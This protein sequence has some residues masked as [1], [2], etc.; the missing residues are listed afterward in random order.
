MEDLQKALQEQGGKTED[1]ILLKRKLE[2]HL[3]KL[4]EA[5]LE[6]QRKREYIEELEP[7]TDSSSK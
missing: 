5:D 2:E 7:P 1:S 6:L 3:Q 4:H